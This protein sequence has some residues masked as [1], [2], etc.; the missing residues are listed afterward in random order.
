MD[1]RLK[2]CNTGSSIVET[3]TI[4]YDI[5][6]AESGECPSCLLW[7]VRCG[8]GA[9]TWLFRVATCVGR[10]INV[11]RNKEIFLILCRIWHL[12]LSLCADVFVSAVWNIINKITFL[13]SSLILF[14]IRVVL[15]SLIRSR[16]YIAHRR[17]TTQKRSIY[18]IVV[19]VS[20][21]LAACSRL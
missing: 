7:R 14:P 5:Y 11:F 18:V 19:W 8:G 4:N 13:A 10:R 9:L 3:V 1:M 20:F 15:Y 6:V 12:S 2:L 21:C 16:I 17:V